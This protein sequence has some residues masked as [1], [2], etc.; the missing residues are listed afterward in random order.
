MYMYNLLR[1]GL[2]FFLSM[3]SKVQG[4]CPT[5]V[6]G[7]LISRPSLDGTGVTLLNIGN[8]IT[9]DGFVTGWRFF[10]VQSEELI[11]LVFRPHVVSDGKYVVV[12]RTII[13]AQTKLNQIRDHKLQDF[14]WI[15]VL[16]GDVIGFKF[17]KASLPY[18]VGDPASSSFLFTNSISKHE[19]LKRTIHTIDSQPRYRSYSFQ[20]VL[21]DSYIP[22]HIINWPL[23]KV[24]T[25]VAHASRIWMDD[26]NKIKCP[27]TITGWQ[28]IAG[29]PG[30]IIALVYRS[31]N[32][33]NN[34]YE[35]VGKTMIPSP[36][37]RDVVKK[38]KLTYSQQID[39]IPGDKIGLTYTDAALYVFETFS[40]VTTVYKFTNKPTNVEVG[41]Q[42]QFTD[43]YFRR[44][45]FDAILDNKEL[46][47]VHQSTNFSKDYKLQNHNIKSMTSRS[48]TTCV[49]ECLN[50]EECHSVNYNE[51]RMT[52]ELNDA[53]V[54][55][56]SGNFVAEAGERYIETS[57]KLT[58]VAG[59]CAFVDCGP[60]NICVDVPDA[61][62]Q[63][64]CMCSSTG[65]LAHVCPSDECVAPLGMESGKIFD[66]QLSAS[67]KNANK[68]GA[69]CGRLNS[70]HSSAGSCNCCWLFESASDTQAWIKI[71]MLIEHNIT[72][73]QT[74]GRPGHDHW[75]KL[76]TI[77]YS[78]VNEL[79]DTVITDGYGRAK[80]FDGNWDR[81]G[82]RTHYFNPVIQAV[83]IK[84]NVKV[85]K[86]FLAMR[87]EVLGCRIGNEWV[88][89]FK[90]V[91]LPTGGTSIYEA[92]ISGSES[93]NYHAHRFLLSNTHYRNKAIFTNWAAFGITKVR[94]TLFS[95][96]NEELLSIIFNGVGTT[97]TSWFTSE[98]IES[99]PWDDIKSATYNYFSVIGDAS[100][101]RR[102]FINKHYGGCGYDNGWLIVKEGAY[103]KVWEGYNTS[104]RILYSRARSSQFWFSGDVG[105][106]RAMTI[107]VKFG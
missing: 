40:D 22:C 63:H 4:T 102:F 77:S 62:G 37:E 98:N 14:D 56:D 82:V 64:L 88:R 59:N 51:D 1:I 57:R 45:A 33:D 93:S 38:F 24:K 72:G 29:G 19:L 10:P 43:H 18:N 66:S 90:G 106:A 92:W 20:A 50:T 75:A 35:V 65:Y 32:A 44:F 61:V 12:G 25:G 105:T 70:K 7:M 91:S 60:G 6:G 89:A 17:Y 27:G 104:P 95:A 11:A 2:L 96:L 53:T 46:T 36:A 28:F 80:M 34:I 41:T 47:Y 94:L 21:K 76:Y 84:I 49:T 3:D 85:W 15:P 101:G 97:T 79:G 58:N 67:S 103:C 74:Q 39:V 78:K 83:S 73:I 16:K 48:P 81:N 100:R 8:T 9:C 26:W 71:D 86:N 30:D 52:C 55:E 69:K 107:D 42:V 31:V 99:S 13:P 54:E 87:V 23:M 68:Y 5:V